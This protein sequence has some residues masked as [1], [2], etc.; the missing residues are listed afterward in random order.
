MADE[1]EYMD[2]ELISDKY[3]YTDS[4]MAYDYIMPARDFDF[5]AVIFKCS[6]TADLPCV[7]AIQPRYI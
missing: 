5:S 7:D 1:W 4:Y 3:R 6:Y 2:M